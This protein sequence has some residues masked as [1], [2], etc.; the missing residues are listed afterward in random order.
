MLSVF[1]DCGPDDQKLAK[2]LASLIP[3]A[4]E[5]IVREVVLV[6]RG[7][8]SDARKVADHAGCRVIQAGDLRETIRAAKGEW[9]LL[10]EPGA[11][12]MP[13]WIGAVIEH[14]ERVD[15]GRAGPPCARFRRAAIDRPGFLRRLRQI[16]AAIAEGFLVKKSQAI[17]LAGQSGVTPTL[18][19]MAKG[20]AVVRLDAEMRPA[21]AASR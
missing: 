19:R 6:D 21:Q 4:V 12:L 18:E 13:G 20:V 15:A 5:G 3:G 16:R 1:I 10:V 14:V 8:G 2:T 11:R 9:L 17:G 7:M